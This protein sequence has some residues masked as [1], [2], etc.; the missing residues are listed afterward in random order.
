M[1]EYPPPE[2]TPRQY[3]LEVKALLDALSM[4]LTDYQ[5]EHR[6]KV[7][8]VD[9][10]YEID[11]TVRFT[12]LNA[13]YLTLIEC[14]HYKRAVE[15]EKVQALH[16]KMQSVGAHKAMVFSTSGF[17][18][19]AIEFAKIHGIALVELADG[20][21][22]YI[23]KG[24]ERKAPVPWSEVPESIPRIVGVLYKGNSRAVVTRDRPD[25]LQS[26]LEE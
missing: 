12:A 5:S 24:A 11:I 25:S 14:K 26:F 22:I 1:I 19:G 16:S 6:E 17:Q 23:T 7:A 10:E 21:S 4:R 20:R 15:R 2:L 9:G 13:D 3:E 8:G 18:S